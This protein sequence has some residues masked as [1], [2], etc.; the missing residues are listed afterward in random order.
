MKAL[1]AHGPCPEHRHSFVNVG[2]V[3]CGDPIPQEACDDPGQPAAWGDA[4]PEN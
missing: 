2:G 3:A 4:G 1:S